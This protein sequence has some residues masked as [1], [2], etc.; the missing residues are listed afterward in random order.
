MAGFTT[1]VLESTNNGNCNQVKDS[2]LISFT[3]AP[4]VDAGFNLSACANNAGSVLS[5]SVFGPTTTGYWSGGTGTFNPD[6]SVLGSTYVPSASEIAAGFVNLILNSSNNGT[7]NQVKDT[8]VINFTNAPLVNAGIDVTVCKNNATT[9]LFGLVSGATT[10]GVWSGVSGTFSPNN[11][12]LT[13]TYTP[14]ASELTAGLL[15]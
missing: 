3:S 1:L 12:A 9:S 4:T 6:S 15:I 10:T 7:C 8:V 2:I 11:T 5:G 13:G 14:S